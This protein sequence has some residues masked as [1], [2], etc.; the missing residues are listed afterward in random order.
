MDAL[1]NLLILYVIFMF[2]SSL[3]KKVNTPKRYRG[4]QTPP[5]STSSG[6]AASS[7]TLSED[8]QTKFKHYAEKVEQYLNQSPSSQQSSSRLS[9]QAGTQPPASSSSEAFAPSENLTLEATD[10]EL[11]QILT[12]P[13]QRIAQDILSGS[14]RF[15]QKKKTKEAGR[16]KSLI[17]AF[18]HP[19]SVLQGIIMSEVLGP[20][21]SKRD[22]RFQRKV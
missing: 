6:H 16:S 20:P 8:I 17:G 21:L 10:K 19:R 12:P 5:S 11:E 14:Q 7:Q 2:F 3:F 13:P 1:L 15:P 18:R 9:D 4:Q 22:P